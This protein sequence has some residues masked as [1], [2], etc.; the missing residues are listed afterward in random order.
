M[1]TASGLICK[2]L[3]AGPG[4]SPK[5][6]DRVKVHYHGSLID[7]TVFDNSVE[8]G[9]PSTFTRDQVIKG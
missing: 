9:E 6:T 4:V 1:Q 8:H 2:E 5:T 3:K 7:G